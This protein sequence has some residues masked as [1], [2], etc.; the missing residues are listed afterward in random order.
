MN[1]SAGNKA[2]PSFWWLCAAVFAI[3][4]LPNLVQD[5][6]FTDGV[7]YAAIA[8]NLATGHGSFWY[9]RFSDTMFPF[10][11]QQPPL[12]FGLQALFF[13]AFGTSIYVE[14]GYSLLSACLSGFLIARIW[15][16][17]Q[18]QN[19]STGTLSWFP[20]LIWITIPVCF[21]SYSNNMEE[22]TMGVFTL[23][24]VLGIYKGLNNSSGGLLFLFLGALATVPA[25]L[26]KGFPGLFPMAIPFIHWLVFRSFSFRR[27]LLFLIITIGVPVVV[28]T[29]LLLIPSV[30]TSLLAYSND[31]VLHSIQHVATEESRFYLIKRL[32]M[33]LSSPA[34]LV[35]IL[36][37]LFKRRNIAFNFAE[38]ELRRTFLFFLFVALSASIP[39]IVTLEQRRFYLVPSLPYYSIALCLLAA[40]GLS[41]LLQKTNYRSTGFRV[42]KVIVI[43]LF[44]SGIIVSILQFGK[45]SRDKDDLQDTYILGQLIPQGSVVSVYPQSWDDWVLHNYFMR[46]FNISL[47]CSET[48]YRYFI[49]EKSLGKKPPA[50]YTLIPAATHK[51][52]LYER[53]P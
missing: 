7:L 24:S 20:V 47:A 2:H 53:F 45:I 22:N 42:F 18:L 11:H 26:C 15:K 4:L 44:A 34:L 35:V 28:Y 8:K 38:P 48:T 39:L 1:T 27:M 17:I 6:M 10:F 52:D 29:L 9:P 13:K 41:S 50:G 16:E 19:I 49:V 37:F 46:H 30:H 21:W 43:I 5:G 51:Y 31:R 25:S 40:P 32:L 23:L 3:V 36:L 33:E 14:R 12:T